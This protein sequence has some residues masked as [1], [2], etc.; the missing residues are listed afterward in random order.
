MDTSGNCVYLSAHL[1]LPCNL[2]LK[3]S[4]STRNSI[5]ISSTLAEHSRIDFQ[6]QIETKLHNFFSLN[7][8]PLH[9]CSSTYIIHFPHKCCHCFL[10]WGTDQEFVGLKD[11]QFCILSFFKKSQNHNYILDMKMNI[12]FE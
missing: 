7:N 1:F 8:T 11:T 10:L 5:L 3:D 9:S 6:Y 12:Y 4:I 2:C